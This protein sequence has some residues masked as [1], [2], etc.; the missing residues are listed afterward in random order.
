[1]EQV[2]FGRVNAEREKGLVVEDEVTALPTLVIYLRGK[3]VSYTG[4]HTS[5]AVLRFVHKLLA[6]SLQPLASEVHLHQALAQVQQEMAHQPFV[7]V[8]GCVDGCV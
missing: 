7:V 1:M 4:Q 8:C 2:P 5:V 6:P 3:R